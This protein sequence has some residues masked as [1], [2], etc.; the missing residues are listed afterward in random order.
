[1]LVLGGRGAPSCGLY[2]VACAVAL[3][4]GSVDY[5]DTEP[6]R[7][8]IA[9]QLGARCVERRAGDVSGSLGSYPVTADATATEVGLALALRST[10]PEGVCTGVGGFMPAST[11][12]FPFTLMY[13][14]NVTLRVE[15]VNARAELDRI[16]P[17]LRGDQ[18]ELAPVV[19]A[20]YRF[21]EAPEAMALAT[22]KVVFVP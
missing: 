16:T 7:L 15:M 11:T 22:A 8:R 6:E 18:L 13:L 17:L 19:T 10:A 12:S 5:V 2:A 3:G 1:V 21:E 14:N 20:R 9:E 4:A